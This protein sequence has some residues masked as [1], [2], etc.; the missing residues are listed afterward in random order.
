MVG[1][2]LDF[3]NYANY[4]IWSGNKMREILVDLP[5]RDFIHELDSFF[6]YRT[7]RV[8]IE[9]I[10]IAVEFSIAL[11]MQKEPDEFSKE[12]EELVKLSNGKL[13]VQWEKT[14]QKY[15]NLL[16]GD[17]SGEIIV[18]DFLGKEFTISKSDFLLQ[19]ITHTTFH[20][21]QLV[22]AL[23]KM[24]KEFMGTDYLHYLYEIAKK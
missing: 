17:L 12:I 2:L 5:D 14:D 20:R 6:S 3:I 7:I 1:Y 22:L 13:L 10:V 18:P 8:L 4:H 21:G 16:K 23:K 9:H 19:Y 11:V 24:G 15:A